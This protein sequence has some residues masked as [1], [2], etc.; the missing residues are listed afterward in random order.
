MPHPYARPV[1]TPEGDEDEADRRPVYLD[2]YGD[3]TFVASSQTGVVH[4]EVP[5]R[6]EDV[7]RALKHPD[8][9]GEP[10]P[11]GLRN[12]LAIPY[13]RTL[14]GKVGRDKGTDER[15]Q[16]LAH[17]AD[18]RL[19]RS[20]HRGLGSDAVLAFEQNQPPRDW[21]ATD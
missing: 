2:D 7:D 4:I 11:E 16:R 8:W 15:W 18:E 13:Q 10:L 9:G 6:P 19:C 21:A 14:C 20:C 17:F 12:F 5:V 3:L 1:P